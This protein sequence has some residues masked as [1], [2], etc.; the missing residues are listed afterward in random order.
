MD[1]IVTGSIAYDYLMRFPGRFTDHLMR[2]KLDQVSLSFLVDDMTKHWGG[3]AAN[4]AYSLALFG[5]HPKVMGTVGRD[6]GDYRL[7]LE[8]AGVDCSTVRQIDDVFTASFFANTDLD[9]NQIA[10]FYSGAMA[11]AR[12]YTHRRRV[13]RHARHGRHLA[14]RPAGDDQPRRR[15]PPAR[16]SLRRRPQPAGAAADGDELRQ[17]IEGAYM[18]VVNAYEAEMISQQDRAVAA[19]TCA[20]RSRSWSSRTASSGSRIYTNGDEIDVP[21]FAPDRDQRPDRR[22]RCLPL[23]AADRAGAWAAAQAG[24]RDGR[25]V[26]D[27]RAGTGRHAEPSLHAGRIRRALPHP[28]RRRRACST[29]C[30]KP[31][32]DRR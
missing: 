23:R 2:E 8:R 15:M 21:V 27:L 31:C 16:D 25:A 26:R 3:N 22:R 18:L 12:N 20:T 1:I 13:R 29:A 28:V 7:W 9:N 17:L 5:L 24:G 30:S 6:F 14:Q 32:A 19:T 10:S 4:I 11:Y